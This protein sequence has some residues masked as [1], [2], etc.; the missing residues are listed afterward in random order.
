MDGF[1]VL[2]VELLALPSTLEAHGRG[3]C[4]EIENPGL[5]TATGLLLPRRWSLQLLRNGPGNLLLVR[6]LHPETRAASRIQNLGIVFGNAL[7]C[8]PHAIQ[9][10]YLP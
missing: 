5:Y 3:V 9:G 2:P 1:S 7:P 4:P 6:H 8:L 10:I